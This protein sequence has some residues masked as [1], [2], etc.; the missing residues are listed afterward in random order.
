MG[1]GRS[2][3]AMKTALGWTERR[4]PRSRSVAGGSDGVM[5]AATI[6]IIIV[7]AANTDTLLVLC[8]EVI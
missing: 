3:T 6:N 8:Q 5:V 1:E 4:V 2:G 7:T